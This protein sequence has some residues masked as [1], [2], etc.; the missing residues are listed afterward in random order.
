MRGKRVRNSQLHRLLSRPFS[1][2]FGRFLDERSS[3]G[4]VSK[5]GCVSRNARARNTHVEAN[6]KILP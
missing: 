1:T 4:T 3:L 2:R 5:R 6:L